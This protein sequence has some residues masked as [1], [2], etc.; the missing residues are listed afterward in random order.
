M[1]ELEQYLSLGAAAQNI[2]HAAYAQGVGA[3]WRTGAVTYHPNTARE[4]GLGE[5]ERLLGACRT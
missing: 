3:M 1:P 5:N 2:L 4:L